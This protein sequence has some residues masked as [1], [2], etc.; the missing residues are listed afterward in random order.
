MLQM[1]MN[2]L[3]RR[4]QTLLLMIFLSQLAF[5]GHL[6]LVDHDDTA[7]CEICLK[8]QQTEVFTT[9]AGISLLAAL[10][11]FV[12]SSAIAIRALPSELQHAFRSRA[13]PC[14][15]QVRY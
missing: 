9:F 2:I 14:T 4:V 12:G 6:V 8:S 11:V 3:S 13:P 7:G 10:V 15:S 5:L 1:P